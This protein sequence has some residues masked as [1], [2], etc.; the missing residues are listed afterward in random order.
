M[1]LITTQTCRV[2]TLAEILIIAAMNRESIR[3]ASEGH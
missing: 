2:F 1:F 3:I